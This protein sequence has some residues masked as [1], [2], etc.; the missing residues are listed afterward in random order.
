MKLMTPS[1]FT[2]SLKGLNATSI[3]ITS[4][5]TA[6]KIRARITVDNHEDIIVEFTPEHKNTFWKDLKANTYGAKVN[7]IVTAVE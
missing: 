1:Q 7:L 5:A 2:Q 4:K 3:Q 6:A